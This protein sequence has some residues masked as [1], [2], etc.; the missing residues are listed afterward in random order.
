MKGHFSQQRDGTHGEPPSVSRNALKKC[1]GSKVTTLANSTELFR[2]K[3]T[4][5]GCEELPGPSD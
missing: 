3:Q 1:R 2:G 4:R 5:A